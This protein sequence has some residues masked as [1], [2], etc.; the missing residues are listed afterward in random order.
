MLAKR[1]TKQGVALCGGTLAAWLAENLACAAMPRSLLLS[2][3]KAASLLAAGQ[4]VTALSPKA[5]ALSEEC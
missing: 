2:T 1:L 5:V 3:I 4:D